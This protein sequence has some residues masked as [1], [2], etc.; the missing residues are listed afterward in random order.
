ML[1][2]EHG[3][4]GLIYEGQSYDAG[5]KLGFLTATVELA[6]KDPELGDDFREYLRGLKL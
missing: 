3:L 4:F 6:L 1:A 5:D 2:A